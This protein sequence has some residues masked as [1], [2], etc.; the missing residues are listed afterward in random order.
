MGVLQE[1][2]R[3]LE[4]AVEGFFARAF[5]SGIQ[6]VELA[7]AIQR[8][9]QDRQTVTAEG[10]VVP[11]VYRVSVSGRDHERLSGFGASLPHE[12][13][14]VV[15]RTAAE[16]NWSLR[17]PAKVRIEVDDE[18][19]LGRYRLKGR[20]EDVSSAGAE[21][22]AHAA[23]SV[24]N[25]GPPR[26]AADVAAPPRERF[27]HTQ[28]VSSPSTSAPQLVLRKGGA[29]P[30]RAMPL[31][32]NRVVVGRQQTCHFVIDD[33]TVSREHAAFVKRGVTWWVVDLGSTNG[34]LV[35]GVQAAEQPV[36]FGDRV[37]LGEAVVEFVEA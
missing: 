26:A 20:I 29:D 12:L 7:K 27:D 37:E 3:R 23:A 2:E 8:Y 16:R 6:P 10:V 15:V 18:L 19:R 30:G 31:T 35:N 14:E 17:G 22:R 34:T 1:F 24:R 32:G 28:V 33:T 25:L 9:A 21:P 11:N 13:A 36:T 5:R 4:G